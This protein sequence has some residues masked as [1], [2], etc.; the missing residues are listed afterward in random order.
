M[1][2]LDDFKKAHESISPYIKYTPLIH[3][4]ELSKNLDVY[5]KLE[6]LQVTGSFKPVSYTHLRAHET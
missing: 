4:L 3:S 1:L 2:N 5:L 6:C